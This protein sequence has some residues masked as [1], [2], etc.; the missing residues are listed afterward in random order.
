VDV[1]LITHRHHDHSDYSLSKRM[2][3]AGKK[4]I[5]PAQLKS[6]W[7]DLA[8]RL[9]TP[10]YGKAQKF[11]PAQ[12]FTMLGSQY[13]KNEPGASGQRVGVPNRDIPEANSET[14][15]YLFRVGDMVFVHGAEN[16]VPE[17]GWLQKGVALG[18]RPQVKL[19]SGQF[20]GERSL[21]AALKNF[22]P[23]FVLPRHEYEMTHE[24]GGNRTGGWFAGRAL[25]AIRQQAAMPL[26]WGET[27]LLA[28]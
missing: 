25:E 6:L 1:S 10:E 26:F 24:H 3:D 18:F 11:G 5:G 19:S 16:H 2:L 22:P 14:V 7:P 15:V 27:F 4:V 13:S 12:I 9:T 17:N 21:E 8:A 20:Q 28:R 23:C